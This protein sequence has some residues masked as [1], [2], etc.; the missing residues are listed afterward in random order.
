MDPAYLHIFYL[1]SNHLS[2][3][4]IT[5]LR[6]ACQDLSDYLKPKFHS[7]AKQSVNLYHKKMSKIDSEE[8]MYS[9][10]NIAIAFGYI[11]KIKDLPL[12]ELTFLIAIKNQRYELVPGLLKRGCSLKTF[13]R[14]VILNPL[15]FPLLDRRLMTLILSNIDSSKSYDISSIKPDDIAF[16]AHN[17]LFLWFL[18]EI[19]YKEITDFQII[20]VDV[21][22]LRMLKWYD[23]WLKYKNIIIDWK[24]VYD[25]KW[26]YKTERW[27]RDNKL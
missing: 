12:N 20:A 19:K 23:K 21:R 5:S 22:T 8:I 27:I 25:T 7:K 16:Y 17:T 9:K 11:K 18:L 1:V 24:S 2:V 15:Y 4:D 14:Q 26:N 13:M 6:L 3:R 10:V